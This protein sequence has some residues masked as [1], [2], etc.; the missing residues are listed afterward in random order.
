MAQGGNA[1]PKKMFIAHMAAWSGR[2]SEHMSFIH[3]LVAAVTPPESQDDRVEARNKASVAATAGDWL[4]HILDHY[5][6]I[7]AAFAAVKAARDAEAR[8]AALKRLDLL[9]TGH[10][11]A[12]EPVIYP[13]L[14]NG[15]EKTH[16]STGYEEQ[17]MVKIQMALLAPMSEDFMDK[18]GHIEG[19]VQHH[20]YAEEG[21]WY[22]DLKKKAPAADQAMLSKR[23]AEKYERYVGAKAPAGMQ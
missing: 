6:G 20:V 16:A 9:L 2:G 5:R 19:A 1:K 21:N 13:V 10:A 8:T 18:L 22:L 11:I 7:E 23:Y 17:A 15:G 12:E 14:A 4:S 3:K